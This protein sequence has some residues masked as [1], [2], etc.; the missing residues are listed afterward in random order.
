MIC[1]LRPFMRFAHR[2]LLCPIFTNLLIGRQSRLSKKKKGTYRLSRIS[3][4]SRMCILFKSL[5][6]LMY[7]SIVDV[8]VLVLVCDSVLCLLHRFRTTN[9]SLLLLPFMN[10]PTR[11]I[12]SIKEGT[13]YSWHI[14]VCYYLNESIRDIVNIK[15]GAWYT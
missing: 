14:N 5:T 9:S 4:I 13:R 8:F 12:V 10:I 15:A 3:I 2:K 7:S 1:I 11:Y 6:I